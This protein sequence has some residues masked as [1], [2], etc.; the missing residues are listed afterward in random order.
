MANCDNDNHASRVLCF[1]TMF[2]SYPKMPSKLDYTR[3]SQLFL[4]DTEP[5]IVAK[6]P[7]YKFGKTHSGYSVTSDGSAS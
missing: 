1:C 5:C 2:T 4:E 7:Y 6:G 3:P